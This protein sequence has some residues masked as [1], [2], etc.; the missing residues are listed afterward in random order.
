MYINVLCNVTMLNSFNISRKYNFPSA[1]EMSTSSLTSEIEV[2]VRGGDTKII[3]A[4]FNI[5]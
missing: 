5:Y 1:V 3:W 2:L 4:N